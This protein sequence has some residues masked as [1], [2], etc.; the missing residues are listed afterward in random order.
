M[1]TSGNTNSKSTA[2]LRRV[3]DLVRCDCGWCGLRSE[4]LHRNDSGDGWWCDQLEC[5]K[6]LAVI[7]NLID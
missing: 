3:K 6:C 4:L 1:T 2:G 5:P 7:E